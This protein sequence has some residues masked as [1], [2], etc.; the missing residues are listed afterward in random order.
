MKRPTASLGL[1]T[2]LLCSATAPVLLRAQTAAA[3]ATTDPFIWLEDVDAQRSMDWVNAHNA[4]TVAELT[5]SPLY[6]PL[7]TR[8]KQ[9]LDSK[10][11]IAYP[12]IMGEKP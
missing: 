11:R 9:V 4:S 5:K 6:Q 2:L 10:D 8:I 3:T 7:Y 12:N 1:L